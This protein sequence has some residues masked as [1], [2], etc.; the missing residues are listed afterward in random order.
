MFQESGTASAKAQG[1]GNSSFIWGLEVSSVLWP[2]NKKRK[3]ISKKKK[4]KKL[5]PLVREKHLRTEI[6][7]R[8]LKQAPQPSWT[9]TTTETKAGK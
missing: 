1:C 2:E 9:S 8:D 4:K 5:K 6:L 3:V 7:M